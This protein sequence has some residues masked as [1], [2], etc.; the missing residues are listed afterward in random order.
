MKRAMGIVVCMA[1]L[2]TFGVPVTTLAGAADQA[3]ASKVADKKGKEAPKVADSSSS[4]KQYPEPIWSTDTAMPEPPKKAP[5]PAPK[6]AP[7]QGEIWSTD[8]VPAP[9]GG[10]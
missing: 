3:S 4:A 6:A 7:Y 8:T 2:G 10:K 9:A 1:V 5:A